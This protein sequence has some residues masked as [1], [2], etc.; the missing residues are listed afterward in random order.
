MTK[1]RNKD[2]VI[3]T[4]KAIRRFYERIGWRDKVDEIDEIFMNSIEEFSY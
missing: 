1:T 4:L 3:N 2:K